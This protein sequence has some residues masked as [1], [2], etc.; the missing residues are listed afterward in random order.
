M[1]YDILKFFL[2]KAS[3]ERAHSIATALFRVTNAVPLM[4]HFTRWIFRLEHP[5]LITRLWGLEFQ[6]PVGLAAGFDKD[7]KY[8]NAMSSL[9]FGFIEVGT[10]T[11]K[12][13]IGNPKPRLFRLLSD[14]A[15]INRMGFNNEG[16]D[17]L[18]ER[19]K[20]FKNRKI[21]IGGNIGKNK[22]TPNDK[23]YKDYLICFN[24]LYP[25]VDYFVVNISSPNTPGLRSLQEKEPLRKILTVLLDSRSLK[26]KS[27]PI[28]LKISPDLNL[29][30]LKDVIEIVTTL[31]IDGIIATNTTVSRDFLKSDKEHIEKIGAGGLSGGPL[32]NLSSEVLKN[33][34]LMTQNK[35]PVI[36]VGGISDPCSAQEKLNA[37]AAM[38]QVYSGLIYEGP[39]LVKRIKKHLIK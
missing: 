6:N 14:R 3:A 17:V 24:K 11:P 39:F 32:K 1:I 28:L 30:Q 16:V 27:K 7:G 31:N 13:Q 34:V 9:G 29:Q 36:G 19:L 4:G 35:L 37:G 38:I 33:V 18:V 23:A 21:I 8:I 25:Y 5:D 26:Q 15:I 22:D 12:P 10:V 20:K 2:F